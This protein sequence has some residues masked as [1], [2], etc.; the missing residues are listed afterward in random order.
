MSD[1]PKTDTG[2]SCAAPCYAEL[3]SAVIYAHKASAVLREIA[4]EVA[5]MH[6]PD[7]AG[8]EGP[9][10]FPDCGRDDCLVC[11]CKKLRDE[12]FQA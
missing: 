3:E 9:D 11:R 10:T 8:F 4:R 1:T 5:E 12:Y 6:C 7:A 2:A